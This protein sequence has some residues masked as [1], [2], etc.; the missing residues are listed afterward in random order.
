MTEYY[1]DLF[2]LWIFLLVLFLALLIV[3]QGRPAAAMVLTAFTV[4]TIALAGVTIAR[5]ATR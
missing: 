5:I 2:V 3:P 1:F 4:V